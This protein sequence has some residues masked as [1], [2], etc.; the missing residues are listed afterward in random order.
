MMG[1]P[2]E[3]LL[4]LSGGKER[5]VVRNII[6]VMQEFNEADINKIGN[7]PIP[8]FFTILEKLKEDEDEMKRKSK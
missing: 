6:R 7:M 3:E 8:T 1:I 5:R 2:K 4:R